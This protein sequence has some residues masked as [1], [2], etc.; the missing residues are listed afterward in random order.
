M[1]ILSSGWTC[2]LWSGTTESSHEKMVSLLKVVKDRSPEEHP[3]LGDQRL[4]ELRAQLA[5]LGPK[6]HPQK[7]YNL[8]TLL[9]KDELR[10]NNLEKAIKH[11]EFAHRIVAM[12]QGKVKVQSDVIAKTA[13]PLAVAYMRL[14]ETENCCLRHTPESCILPIVGDGRHVK[15]EG[16][17]QAITYF[18]EVLAHTQPSDPRHL[19]ARW[20]LNI[21]HQTLGTWPEGVDSAYR[22]SAD[23]FTNTT[24]FPR[25][26]N[27]A[28]KLGLDV[29]DLAGGAIA[30][31]FDKDGDLDI[32]V[33]SY[34]PATHLRYFENQQGRF[35]DKSKAANLTGLLGGFNLV[36]ADFD[37][38]GWCDFLVLRG[39]WLG[40]M[41]KVPNSL[42]RNNG[43][44][45]FTDVS[46]AAGIAEPAYPSQTA[47]WA[48]Y[49][50]DGDL[51]LFIGGEATPQVS[52]PCQLFRNNGDGTFT[53]VAGS[54][55]VRNYR[56]TKSAAW[57]DYDNDGDP[58]LYVSNIG[59]PN[60]LY[61]N[62]G[63]GTFTD[64]ATD[65]EV[66]KPIKSFPTWF[67]DYNN[68]GALDIYVSS[69]DWDGGSL[70]S[71]VADRL[72]LPYSDE[73]PRLYVGDGKGGFTE[74]GKAAGIGHLSL[75]MGANYGDL[76]GDGFLDFYLGTGYPDYEAL[77]PNVMFRNKDGL[78]FEEITFSGGFGH[79]QKGHA[80]VFA[81]LDNDGDQDVYE[82]IG[83]FLPGDRYGNALFENPGHNN[84]WLQLTLEGVQSNRSAIGTR[85][86]ATLT[87]NGT[88]RIIHRT[89]NSGGSF[90]ANSLRCYLGLGK[91]LQVDKL[92]VFWPKTRKTQVFKNIKGKQFYKL[93]EGSEAL[94]VMPV[95]PLIF[96]DKS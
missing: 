41:G 21:C 44:G 16:S 96:Q 20:L 42:V 2:P 78:G 4:H 39:G 30:E 88:P 25:F 19:K 8:H 93:I 95:K 43:D 70:G 38:D 94:E 27:I 82:Q 84:N 14:G 15:K 28:P 59:D 79:L 76:D 22:I 63:D 9:G 11:L 92:E 36:Q 83:G 17:E 5:A 1:L 85:L 81:D 64:V 37:N 3:I 50:L 91:A 80:V 90:G 52:A 51:D 46:F 6:P 23:V 33:S 73:V 67:F 66:G 34:D 40:P 57:G 60:R 89:I 12:L 65:L 29:F 49:D 69:Y 45:T 75:P 18:N 13:W 87:E 86:K 71:V 48:D 10:A 77:M 55:G 62:N 58:D 56:F 53:D 72:G 24:S 26:T 31:D 35:V 74:S 68:D 61:R 47:G 54:T 32:L 7:V